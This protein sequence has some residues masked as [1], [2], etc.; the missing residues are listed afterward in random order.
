MAAELVTKIHH[1]K[2]LIFGRS[3]QLS[4]KTK[5]LEWLMQLKIS[6]RNI[7]STPEADAILLICYR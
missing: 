6:R 1:F 2:T 5:W 3:N 7:E 4:M